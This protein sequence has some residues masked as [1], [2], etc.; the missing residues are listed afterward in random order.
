MNKKKKAW[1]YTRGGKGLGQDEKECGQGGNGRRQTVYRIRDLIR[2]E[3]LL[4]L[5]GSNCQLHGAQRARSMGVDTVLADYTKN[6]LAASVCGVHEKI[7]TFDV[8]ACIRAAKRYGVTG[9]M[10]M[11]TDQ[12]VYTCA[13]I[14][15]ELGLPGVQIFQLYKQGC[16][17]L[18]LL[19]NVYNLHQRGI[20][21]QFHDTFVDL[22]HTF[23]PSPSEHFYYAQIYKGLSF[24]FILKR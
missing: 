20:A 14:S 13:C 10:T 21:Y 11:G 7:S 23:P 12:P 22:G 16:L 19:F 3:K 1:V 18:F 15:R 8:Q 24:I 6:P 2:P 9:V 17:Q 5:G 4:M